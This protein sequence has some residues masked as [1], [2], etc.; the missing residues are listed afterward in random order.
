MLV[1][2]WADIIDFDA[3]LAHM[4]QFFSIHCGTNHDYKKGRKISHPLN[5]HQL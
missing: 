4:K 5:K 3:F 2:H 1:S